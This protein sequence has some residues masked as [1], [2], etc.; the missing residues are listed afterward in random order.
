MT[1]MRTSKSFV[2]DASG[3]ADTYYTELFQAEPT[4]RRISAQVQRQTGTGTITATLQGGWATSMDEPMVPGTGY[5][6]AVLNDLYIKTSGGPVVYFNSGDSAAPVWD[7]DTGTLRSG[8]GAPTDGVTVGDTNDFYVNT[9]A[10]ALDPT[11]GWYQC[12]NGAAD[13][14]VAVTAAVTAGAT[15]P[16]DHV[17][18]VLTDW[19]NL[20]LFT[21]AVATD[22][23][24]EL[25]D[26]NGGNYLFASFPCYRIKYVVGAAAATAQAH[27]SFI[28]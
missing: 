23:L 17:A 1:A 28:P 12:D 19:V 22:Q 24:T 15:P 8:A 3:G 25:K 18:A 4:A 11:T 27:V 9:T 13:T 6:V 2:L 5:G 16:I 26:T 10:Y 21:G 20:D 7:L 14:W